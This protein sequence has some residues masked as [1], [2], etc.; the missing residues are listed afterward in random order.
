MR[1][2]RPCYLKAVV[3]VH[4]KSKSKFVS[5]LNQIYD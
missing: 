3:I 4:G 5:I 1:K 2:N